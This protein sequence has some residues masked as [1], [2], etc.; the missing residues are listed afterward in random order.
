MEAAL[1]SAPEIDAAGIGVA[2]HVGVATLTGEVPTYWQKATAGKTALR[3]RGVTTLANDIEV[4]HTGD[5]K[6]DTDIAAAVHQVPTWNSAIPKDSIKVDIEDNTVTL[7]GHVDWNFQREMAERLVEP[8]VGVSAV[9]NRIAL[10]PRPHA[11]SSDRSAGHPASRHHGRAKRRGDGGRH[12][13]RAHGHGLVVCRETAGRDRCMVV[14]ERGSR[15]Q[16]D[17][18]RNARLSLPT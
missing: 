2:V 15:R 14:A 1:E 7:S 4:H 6:S 13:S 3:T 5:A 8:L 18:R 12:T 11:S 10:T 9:K 16:Q 17:R